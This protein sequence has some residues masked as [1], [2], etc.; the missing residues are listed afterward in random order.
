MPGQGTI[1]QAMQ[2]GLGSDLDLSINIKSTGSNV[3]ILNKDIITEVDNSKTAKLQI[4]TLNNADI[5]LYGSQIPISANIV[6]NQPV[7]TDDDA[8]AVNPTT[9]TTNI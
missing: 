4:R 8:I 9:I 2:V 3:N 7:I 5:Y 1:A 6:I